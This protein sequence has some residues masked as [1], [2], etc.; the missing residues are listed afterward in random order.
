MSNGSPYSLYE[1]ELLY[2]TRELPLRQVSDEAW[3]TPRLW[4]SSW[5]S[6]RSWKEPLIHTRDPGISARPDQ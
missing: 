2:A 3:W 5:P 6:V 1:H 4:L